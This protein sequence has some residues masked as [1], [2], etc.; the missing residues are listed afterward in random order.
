MSVTEV[1]PL[2]A[3]DAAWS[4]KQPVVARHLPNG[5]DGGST[6]TEPLAGIYGTDPK[7][8]DEERGDTSGAARRIVTGAD[9]IA[10]YAAPYWLIDGIVQRGRLYSCTS[11]TAHGKTAVWLYNGCMIHAGRKVG[12][13]N[14]EHI[15][16]VFLAGE[17]PEDLKARTIGM[18]R[19]FNLTP[20]QLPYVLPATFPMTEESAEE[21]R[22]N[23]AALGVPVGLIICDTAASFFPGDDENNNVQ[24]GQYAR[25]LRTLTACPGNPAVVALCHPV[26]GA[27]RENLLPRGG[28]AF[29]NE[30]D[31]NLTLWSD[32]LGE[33]T[34]LHWQGKIRGPDFDPVTYRLKPVDIGKQDKHK[35]D[36][37]T[38]VAHPID[39]IQATHQA[40]QNVA[41]EDAVLRAIRDNPKWSLA[42][43]ARHLGWIGYQDKPERWRVQRAI[44]ALER[45]KLV[46]KFRGKYSITEAGKTA[47]EEAKKN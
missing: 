11:L 13:L 18:A 43:I 23:I 12:H 29:L 2:S 16:V 19:T 33:T 30:L 21:L 26:K 40:A 20:E 42:D 17:N 1:D 47:L 28:G 34:T 6:T 4:Q 22:R 24:N 32:Q 9:F 46:R 45:E 10:S 36:I 39:E 35:R 44:K 41:N 5:H 8:K 38:V 31:G 25:T 37:L 7:K 14:A 3:T 27:G 15:N